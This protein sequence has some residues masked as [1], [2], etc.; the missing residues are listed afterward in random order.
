MKKRILA[1]TLALSLFL[2]S[3]GGGKDTTPTATTPAATTTPTAAMYLRRTEGTVSVSDGGGKDVPLLDNLSLYSGYGVG[4]RSASYAWIGLDDV[5]L[6]KLDQRSEISIEKEGKALNIELRSGS[7]FFNVTEP[8]KD[9]ETMNI[10]TSAMLVGIRGACGW[11]VSN[12]ERGAQVF[13]LEGTVEAEAAGAGETV[14]VTAGSMAEVTVNE[15]G[16]AVTTVQPFI[17]EHIAPFVLTELENDA[18][19]RAAVLE[20]S[21]LDILNPPDPARRLRAEYMGIIN[22][23]PILDKYASEGAVYTANG[24]T[25]ASEGLSYAAII[26][27]DGNGTDEL[28]LVTQYGPWSLTKL[29]VYGD[30]QGY[31]ALYGEADLFKFWEED[32]WGDVDAYYAPSNFWLAENNGHIYAVVMYGIQDVKG[33][34]VYTVENNE[35]VLTKRTGFSEYVGDQYAANWDLTGGQNICP[36]IPDDAKMKNALSACLDTYAQPAD[37]YYAKLVNTDLYALYGTGS[38]EKYSWN[39]TGIEHTYLEDNIIYAN[40]IDMDQDGEEELLLVSK[41]ENGVKHIAAYSWDN[42]GMRKCELLDLQDLA[43]DGIYRNKA[44]G[45]I[46]IGSGWVSIGNAEGWD[47][48]SLTDSVHL[49]WVW[50]YSS[51]ERYWIYENGSP[52]E[53]REL[54][55]EMEAANAEWEEFAAQRDRFEL[56]EDIN[57]SGNRFESFERLHYTVDKVRRQLTTR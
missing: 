27:L 8:P 17:E 12:G 34:L 4:T 22:S 44:A 11:V 26:D 6:A 29:E 33:T 3:C 51:S 2:S 47:F 37:Y 52:E 41:K 24:L 9:D 5:K 43:H 53:I 32:G 16:E 46:Y 35:L 49:D 28:I 21:G 7:L 10:R 39:G 23:R 13:L 55:A 30:S 45:D 31:A 42:T 14:R 38:F 25:Y 15:S 36:P 48:V 18:A 20:A 57:L 40:L 54:E 19:L 56:I 1:L 50:P